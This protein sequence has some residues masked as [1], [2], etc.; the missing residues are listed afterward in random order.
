MSRSE[1]GIALLILKD[2]TDETFSTRMYQNE[3]EL[4][5]DKEKYTA[6]NYQQLA[7]AMTFL[8]S[9][10]YAVRIGTTD[11]LADALAIIA[12][13]VKTGWIAHVG[14]AEDYTALAE[15]IKSQRVLNH[16]TYKGIVFKSAADSKYIVNLA[17][18]KVTFLDS[19]GEQTGDK[20]IPSLLGILAA[21]NISR[22]AT[23]YICAN[24]KAAEEPAD[25]ND[26][27]TAGKMILINDFDDVRIGLGIN[28][29]TTLT[30]NDTEDMKYIDI[31]ETMD[32][33]EDDIRDTFK[34]QYQGRYKNNLDNQMLFVSAVN[35][36][37]DTLERN[38][39]LDNNYANNAD[40]DITAQRAAWIAEKPEAEYWDD[41]TVRI[42]TYKRDVFL[43]GNIKILGAM[44]NLR[45]PISMF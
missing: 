41:A 31:V 21:C 40:I 33:I 6:E 16:R 18:E 25:V 37:F 27:L 39:V 29:M 30:G 17:N 44:E 34:N 35:T 9:K 13:T 19:R 32:L 10:L 28:S 38:E 26:A 42:T 7:D 23:N 15:W 8:P 14:T 1:R 20:Y 4:F 5:I 11:T 22:G 3:R 43:D 45:F 12:K 2:D 36:Y 24:L